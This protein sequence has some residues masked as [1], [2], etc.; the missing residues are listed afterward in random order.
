[1]KKHFSQ[2]GED[3]IIEELLSPLPE[4]GNYID[5]GANHPTQ[6][7]VTKYFYDKGWRG[8]NIEPLK[9]LLRLYPDA[10]PGDLTLGCVLG[11]KHWYETEAGTMELRREPTPNGGLST[12]VESYAKPD[13]TITRVAMTTLR[14]VCEIWGFEQYE[15]LKI[16][17]EGWEHEVLQ[18]AD[19][20]KHRPRVICIEAF[21]P[22]TQIPTHQEW[23]HILTDAGYQHVRSDIANR[24]YI[25]PK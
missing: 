15:F 2:N 6:D 9:H 22:L 21:E 12:L 16:D 18:G 11:S 5:V 1:M 10:R 24:Y 14:E 13:W 19:F 3:R 4:Y 25:L 7:N 17:V 8:I 20:T 23:E